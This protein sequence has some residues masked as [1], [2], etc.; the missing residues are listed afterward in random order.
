MFFFFIFS[1]FQD[2]VNFKSFQ[3]LL[4]PEE[5]D[6]LLRYLPAIDKQSPEMIEDMFNSSA[7][8]S[9]LLYFQVEN[10]LKSSYNFRKC[11][12]LGSLIRTMMI[13][14]NISLAR[15]NENSP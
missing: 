5:K 15:K 8:H 7:F 1:F 2:V 12:K 6:K 14:S 4:T 11:L 10:F 9:H 3:T 13:T